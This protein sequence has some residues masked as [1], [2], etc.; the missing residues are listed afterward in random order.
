MF[1]PPE[2][3]PAG[4]ADSAITSPFAGQY[5][6]QCLRR[7]AVRARRRRGADALR[8]ICPAGGAYLLFREAAPGDLAPAWGREFC[9]L[10]VSAD[11]TVPGV[12]V[13][14]E[15]VSGHIPEAVSG[16]SNNAFTCSFAQKNLCEWSSISKRVSLT[17]LTP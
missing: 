7:E 12:R 8:Q 14:A 15:T 13:I 3:H 4:H 9:G 17:R 1:W 10:E 11:M 16:C 5:I 6:G 2:I